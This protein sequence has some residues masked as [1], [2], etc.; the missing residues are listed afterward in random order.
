M[1]WLTKPR[2]IK[3]AGSFISAMYVNALPKNRGNIDAL[4]LL[5]DWSV[6]VIAVDTALLTAL[7]VA[8]I[9]GVVKVGKALLT[10]GIYL[11]A[12]SLL[13]TIFVL[14]ALPLIAEQL[15]ERSGDSPSIYLYRIG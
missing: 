13:V 4:N 9:S 10:T 7:G 5:K 15:R 3:E 11:L 6:T 2:F 1:D 12:L 14:G 8:L